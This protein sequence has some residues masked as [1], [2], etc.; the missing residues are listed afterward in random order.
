M[1]CKHCNTEVS[2]NSAFCPVCGQKLEAE[3]QP[4]IFCI[5]CETE[6]TPDMLF[7]PVCGTK[8]SSIPAE[9]ETDLE[10]ELESLLKN[11]PEAVQVSSEPV[12]EKP[13][14]K[15]QLSKKI[16]FAAL[17]VAA[18]AAIAL[19]LFSGSSK[20][21][22]VYVKDGQLYHAVKGAKEAFVLSDELTEDELEDDD[23]IEAATWLGGVRMSEDGKKL[24][25]P[26]KYEDKSY[27]L[28]YQNIANTKKDPVKLDSGLTDTYYAINS[29]GTQVTYLKDGK[30]YQHDLKEKTKIDNDVTDFYVSE[31]GSALI[32]TVDEDSGS[33]PA[34]TEAPAAA[35]AAAS[36]EE[37]PAEVEEKKRTY[38]GFELY[39]KYGKE[40]PI[41]LEEDVYDWD[42]SEDLS[43][44]YFLV[45]YDL[46]AAKKGSDPVKLAT[47]V[48]EIQSVNN[49]GCYYTVQKEDTIDLV[50]LIE[51]DW[52]NDDSA[53]V[54]EYL[55]GSTIDNLLYELYYYNGKENLL[56]EK[57]M[58]EFLCGHYEQQFAAY[59]ALEGDGMPALKISEFMEDNAGDLYDQVLADKTVTYVAQG[60]AATLLELE[61]IYRITVNDKA[62]TLWISAEYDKDAREAI[63]YEVILS[64]NSIKSVDEID[65]EVYY[66]NI[67]TDGV[68]YAYWKNVKDSEGELCY[69]G[70]EI[71]DDARVYYLTMDKDTGKAFLAMDYSSKRHDYTL[72]CWNGKK[73]VT[74]DEEVYDHRIY[75]DNT[76][77]YLKDYSTSKYEGDLYIWDGKEPEQVD[78]DVAYIF[79]VYKIK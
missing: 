60:T 59:T 40:D 24:F 38:N 62:D 78:E 65:D 53:Y 27:T 36:D 58:L 22:I 57:Q 48:Q 69:N 28:Y 43:V 70:K 35:P 63:L 68:N 47:D 29:D 33:V 52:Q 64:G 25:Y 16:L 17:G 6:L 4:G 32:Y 19:A 42:T 20:S 11:E 76:V 8:N 15:I 1:I 72:A 31:N 66:G 67:W 7:C 79:P 54:M 46:Y 61:D 26:A 3:K 37:T 21:G 13:R 39:V 77:V 45:N 71:A 14:K 23:L 74:V 49:T 75:D 2:E 12:S 18:A 51:D 55:E 50:S 73:L 41:K 10:I 56:V 5:N 9:P 30:L 44:V 34:A